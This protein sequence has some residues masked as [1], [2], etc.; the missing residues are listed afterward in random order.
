MLLRN[1]KRKN[2]SLNLRKRSEK[3]REKQ[4][5]GSKRKSE[6]SRSLPKAPAQTQN[7]N[8]NLQNVQ[9]SKKMESKNLPDHKQVVSS[10]EKGQTQGPQPAPKTQKAQVAANPK[11]LFTNFKYP[12]AYSGDIQKFLLENEA[13][14]RHRKRIKKFDRR[15]T[16]VNGPFTAIQVDTIFGL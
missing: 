9:K 1:Q 7:L 11:D 5:L 15:R 4:S 3:N 16:R 10:L 14:S 12:S 2:L 8:Q 6:N 13:V